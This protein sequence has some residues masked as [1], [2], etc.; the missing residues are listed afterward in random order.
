MLLAWNQVSFGH[1]LTSGY[2]FKVDPSMA[3]AH[4]R[5]V[6]G[7][8][9]PGLEGLHGLLLSARRGLFFMAPW[10]ILAPV[11]AVWICRDRR[12]ARGWRLI[13][14]LATLLVPILLSGFSDWHGGQTLGPRYLIFVIPLF[15]VAAT[16]AL[17][18][19]FK[20]YSLSTGGK[21]VRVRIVRGLGKTDSNCRPCSL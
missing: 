16:I 21:T 19:L 6:L 7:L 15:G 18:V 13:L 14:L 3:A 9:W 5:G 4:A 20:W 17:V 8:S 12:M 1:P 2:A 11:G 10:L